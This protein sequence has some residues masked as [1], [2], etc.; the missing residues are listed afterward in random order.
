[1][2][3]VLISQD[4]NPNREYGPRPVNILK[5]I[6]LNDKPIPFGYDMDQV[7]KQLQVYKEAVARAKNGD[8]PGFNYSMVDLDLSKL[9]K[10]IEDVVND[11]NLS[12]DQALIQVDRNVKY[13]DLVR[14]IDVYSSL[15]DA[16]HKP[17]P[18]TKVSFSELPM[19]EGGS[20][21]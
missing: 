7:N 10:E 13:S 4:I 21:P 18:L 14:V 5:E 19:I 2:K 15:E 8:E 12:F 6:L 9:K 1:L 16:S 20:P 3:T 17:K 11:P